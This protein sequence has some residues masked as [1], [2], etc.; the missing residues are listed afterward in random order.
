MLPVR[1]VFVAS[2]QLRILADGINRMLV[3]GISQTC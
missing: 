3:G 2:E 1:F